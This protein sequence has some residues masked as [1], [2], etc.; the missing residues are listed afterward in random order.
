ME[1]QSA[2]EMYRLNIA[3]GKIQNT[4]ESVLLRWELGRTSKSF[5][6]SSIW[7]IPMFERTSWSARLKNLES[8]RTS[9]AEEDNIDEGDKIRDDNQ[10]RPGKR[11]LP[12]LETLPIDPSTLC[13]VSFA[14]TKLADLSMSSNLRLSVGKGAED[15]ARVAARIFAYSGKSLLSQCHPHDVAR[16][17]YSYAK[18]MV[19]AA[20]SL[21]NEDRSMCNTETREALT[22]HFTKRVVQVINDSVSQNDSDVTSSSFFESMAPKHL[23]NLIWSLSELGVQCGTN[24][25]SNDKQ[26]SRQR[27][28]RLSVERPILSSMQLKEMSSSSTLNLVS[29]PVY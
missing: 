19:T 6:A 16:V 18:S 23:A 24:L 5:G 7:N 21:G 14:Y 10:N 11:L 4:I 27:K 22:R 15:L 17:C 13:K 1:K 9:A 3:L 2:S 20:V 8:S 25:T 26:L 28:L 29:S 12:S